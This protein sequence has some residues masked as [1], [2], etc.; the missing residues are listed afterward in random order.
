MNISF[1]NTSNVSAV[2]TL[3]MEKADYDANVKKSLKEYSKKAQM[4]GFRPGKVPV[5]LIQKI[6]GQQAKAEEVNKLLNEK[7]FEYIK[8]NKINML[9]EPLN[10]ER[11]QPQDIE[12]QDDFEF[13]FDIALAPDFNIAFTDKDAVNY[14]D[15]DISEEQIDEEIKILTQRFGHTENVD[16]YADQDIL[17]GI[18]AELDENGSVKEDGIQI[19]KASLMPTYFKDTEQKKIFEGSTPNMVL[20]FNPVKAYE[21]NEAEVASL[22]KIEKEKVAEHNGNFSFQIEEISRFM[23]AG[24]NQ[25]FY[26]QVLGKDSVKDENEFRAKIKENLL[27]RH[28]ADSD[29]KFLLDLREYS[30]KKV[31]ELEFPDELLKRIMKANNKDK[32]EQFFE[33]NYA[34]SIEE[35]KWHLIKEKIVEAYNIKV[36]D[37][38][39]KATAMQ[40]TRFQ[41]AQYGMTNIPNEYLEQ[42]AA[43][44]LKKKEQVNALVE[45]CIDAKLTETL[46]QVVTL[47]HKQISINEFKELFKK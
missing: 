11:Q 45:R 32:D 19:S 29:Y 31:G 5:S 22:L 6:Y 20:T 40:A 35:L 7:L 13:I 43:E 24:L 46:K 3:K 36:N 26:D 37:N 25:D 2:L 30:E 15:I 28:T 41:F 16:K 9:G 12:N 38:D 23:P 10:S 44:M 18:L 8:E 14:Y 27:S 33:D 4:P 21:G 39:L 34:K 42:Y 17:R 47:N 1:E